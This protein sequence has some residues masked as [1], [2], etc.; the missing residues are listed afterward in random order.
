MNNIA[1]QE[2]VN[3]HMQLHSYNLSFLILHIDKF[4]E[5][6]LNMK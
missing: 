4:I 2:C 1:L 3:V 5:A 6:V